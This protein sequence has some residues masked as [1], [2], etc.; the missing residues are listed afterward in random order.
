MVGI[1]RNFFRVTAV[2]AVAAPPTAAGGASRCYCRV[3]AAGGRDA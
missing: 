1:V 2:V 3:G